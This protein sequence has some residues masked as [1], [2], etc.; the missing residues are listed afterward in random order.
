MYHLYTSCQSV[1]QLF[2]STQQAN[3]ALQIAVAVGG[4]RAGGQ[5]TAKHQTAARHNSTQSTAAWAAATGKHA[6]EVPAV[7]DDILGSRLPADSG[8]PRQ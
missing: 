4:F 8:H 7:P 6:T 2:S 3:T 1:T 5:S